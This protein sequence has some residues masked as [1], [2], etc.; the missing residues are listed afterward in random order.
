MNYPSSYDP[1]VGN[2]FV[3]SFNDEFVS[4]IGNEEILWNLEYDG[5]LAMD[6]CNKVGPNFHHVVNGIWFLGSKIFVY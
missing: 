6:S 5:G 4:V 3:I 2:D 1:N